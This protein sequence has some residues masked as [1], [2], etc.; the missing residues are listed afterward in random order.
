MTGSQLRVEMVNPLDHA[1][2]IKS[3]MEDWWAPGD[4][5][6]V[7]ETM[8]EFGRL[9]RLVS[10]RASRVDAEK[11]QQIRRVISDAYKSI[12]EIIAT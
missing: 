3:Q 2:G 8:R 12:E 11:M 1:E 5:K 9:A 4:M 6:E 7:R 10:R